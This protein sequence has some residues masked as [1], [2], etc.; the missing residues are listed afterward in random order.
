M[1]SHIRTVA[2]VVLALALLGLFLRNV[3]FGGVRNVLNAA[4]DAGSVRVV[5]LSSI[6]VLGTRNIDH[7]VET[8]PTRRER[9]PHADVK[10]DAEEYAAKLHRENGV[11]VVIL[12]PGLI[13]GPG[14]RNIAKLVE[15][16]RRGK[17]SYIGGRDHIV[18]IVHV[19]DV[20]QAMLLAAR[21]STA[22]SRACS[23]AR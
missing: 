2:V 21:T 8:L 17:F 19:R 6:N 10:I 5:L 11:D 20:V 9:E 3:N 14:E 4:R 22:E 12:R 1:R 13:Y 23:G 18:P 7:A 15:T 16:L